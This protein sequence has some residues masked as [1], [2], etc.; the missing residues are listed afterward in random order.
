MAVSG[1]GPAG[2]IWTGASQLIRSARAV[3]AIDAQGSGD[4]GKRQRDAGDHQLNVGAAR[5]HAHP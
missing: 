4:D 1:A 3:A 2:S 5:R